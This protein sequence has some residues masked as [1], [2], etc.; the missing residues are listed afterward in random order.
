MSA[1][2]PESFEA[3]RNMREALGSAGGG[4]AHDWIA[5]FLI[6]VAALFAISS[7]LSALALPFY[8]LRLHRRLKQV[9]RRLDA[10]AGRLL[11][12]EPPSEED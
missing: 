3:L 9:E 5:A 4:G 11:P 2:R 10:L 1:G 6:V 12:H 7:V 8:L